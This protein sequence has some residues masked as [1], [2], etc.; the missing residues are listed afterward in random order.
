MLT[1]ES[2]SEFLGLLDQLIF[3]QVAIFLNDSLNSSFD[4]YLNFEARGELHLFPKSFGHG[5]LANGSTFVF[6][7]N[8]LIVID[9]EV[10]DCDE[11]FEHFISWL[12]WHSNATECTAFV[13]GSSF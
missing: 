2:F 9:L 7:V 1:S 5:A 10:V 12:G 4:G 11:V 3:G 13:V 8:G 6:D